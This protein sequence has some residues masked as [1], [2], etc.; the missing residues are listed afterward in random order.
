M[1]TELKLPPKSEQAF[2][3]L[4][5]TLDGEAG[6]GAEFPVPLRHLLFKGGRGSAKS[7]SIARAL[8]NIAVGRRVRILCTREVMKTI[9]ES[10]YALLK[11]IVEELGFQAFFRFTK[12]SIIGLNGSEFLFSGLRSQDIDKI[13]SKE[14]INICW[15]EEAH[16]LSNKSLDILT[17]TIRAENSCLVYSYNPELDDDPVH[18]R[19]ALVPQDDVCVVTLNWRDN[20]WFPKVLEAE[21]LR[22]YERD[23]TEGRVNYNWVWEGQTLPAVHGAIFAAEVARL[24][25]QGRVRPLEYDGKGRVHVVMDLGYGVMTAILV[26]KFASTVQV[27]GYKELTHSTYHDLTLQLKPM[28]WRWGKVFMPHDAAHRDPKYGK[29]HFEVMQELG[30]EVAEIENIGIENYIE[31]GRQLFGNIYISDSDDCAQLIRCLK[32]WRYQMADTSV[33]T[34]KTLPPMKDEFSHGAE[35]FC[36]LAVVADQLTNDETVISDPYRGFQSGYAA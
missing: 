19:Y 20:D 6:P 35:A 2:K 8:V 14:R 1:T 12:N 21:R 26:Q 5:A 22:D 31:A 28:P 30:W 29:S 10:V 3:W 16:V 25:E 24:Q 18:E 4:L 11:D 32:R 23:N 15:C 27:I 9:E 17:P 7:H 34:Q 33:G 36:Y 13:R